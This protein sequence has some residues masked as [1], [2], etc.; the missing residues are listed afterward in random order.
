MY[1]KKRDTLH[2]YNVYKPCQHLEEKI[3]RKK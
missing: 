3:T 1:I 2:I